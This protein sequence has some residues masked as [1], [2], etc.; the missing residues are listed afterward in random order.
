M[1]N[2][3]DLGHLFGPRPLCPRETRVVVV[4]LP[5]SAEKLLGEGVLLPGLHPFPILRHQ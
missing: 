1:T 2:V 5:E 4:G 3:L